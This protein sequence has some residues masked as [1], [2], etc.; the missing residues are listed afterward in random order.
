M[1]DR[2]RQHVT[3][4]VQDM[5][6]ALSP[7]LE[8]LLLQVSCLLSN[9]FIYCPFQLVPALP[10]LSYYFHFCKLWKQNQKTV[11]LAMESFCVPPN[12]TIFL[13]QDMM[14]PFSNFKRALESPN[15][16]FFLWPRKCHLW[17]SEEL[18]I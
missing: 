17:F 1:V 5:S 11:L 3:G 15:L 6:Q 18:V 8:E 9:L 14:D 4:Q 13:S 16:C 2:E 12:L 7:H 10:C